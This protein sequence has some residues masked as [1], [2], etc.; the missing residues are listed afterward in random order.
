MYLI[1]EKD[2]LGRTVFEIVFKNTGSIYS[3]DG[4]ANFLAHMLNTKG[5]LEEKEKFYSKLEEKAVNIHVTSNKEFTTVSAVFLNEK[6]FFAVKKLIELIKTPNFSKE[7]F[8][9]TKKEILAKKENLKNNHDYIASTNLYKIMFKDTPVA[10]PVIGENIE[11]IT[12][13][14]IKKHYEYLSKHSAVFINGGKRIS[15][16]EI[17]E[18]LPNTPMKKDMFFETKTGNITEKREVE[19]SYIYF[20]SPFNVKK[21]EFYLAKIA[22]FILGAG[23]FG[24]RMMEEIRVKKGYAYSAYAQ[25]EFK[26]SYKILRGHLQTKLENTEDALKI[27][28]ELIYDFTQNG[29]TQE[30]L[31]NAKKFLIGS[32]PLRN[33]TLAQRLLRKFNEYYLG[34]GEGYYQKE[35]NLIKNA[36]LEEVNYFIKKHQEINN[37]SFSIVTK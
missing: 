20:G 25:N 7:A 36:K 13:N 22:T 11:N 24:S 21:E 34:L 32:E 35:L 16:E 3:K 12:I 19:Q 26:K 23:G 37:L 18:V 15:I 31:D 9:K 4:V 28:K 5:T 1:Y 2:N 30:E 27:V 29:I 10:L 6:S 33:E 14:D 17:I 8:E